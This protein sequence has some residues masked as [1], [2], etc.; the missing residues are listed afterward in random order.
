M[1]IFLPVR[2][3]TLARPC[4]TR[5]FAA[6]TPSP[7]SCATPKRPSASPPR[8]AS[9]HRQPRR[10]RIVSRRCRSAGRL[11]AHGA[12]LGVR[13]R[14][15][16]REL[17]IETILAAAKRP[18]TA[19]REFRTSV[20]SFSRR[21]SGCSAR[22]RIRSPRTRRRIRSPWRRIVPTTNVSC[23]RPRRHAADHGRAA[24]RRL[25]RRQR[26]RR[27][28]LQ[29]GHQRPRPRRWRRRQSLA[30]RLR[31][32]SGGPVR[33]A[34]G[35]PARLRHLPR[36][37]RGRRARQRYRVRDFAV[38]PVRPMCG[39]C[40][41]R[42]ADQDGPYADALASIRSSEVRARGRSAGRRRC[43]PSPATPPGCS[44]SGARRG[45]SVS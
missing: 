15:D 23:S 7:R 20:S 45:T 14:S 39:T 11:R 37:R 3:A 27:R 13:P 17:A 42:G 33:E 18:R 1:R 24:R 34:G 41:S 2:P 29:V 10:R 6:A 26:D 19:R 38:L 5:C 43:I 4:S 44:R 12:R 28:H 25:R 30:A 31:P 40:R 8:R 32:R 16:H 21:A 9:G 35:E 36:Q 22:R